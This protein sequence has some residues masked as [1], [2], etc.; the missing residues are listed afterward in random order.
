MP[1]TQNLETVK[2]GTTPEISFAAFDDLFK[3]APDVFS[4]IARAFIR[5]MKTTAEKLADLKG[6]LPTFGLKIAVLFHRF[7]TEKRKEPEWVGKDPNDYVRITL[8]LEK[9]D[10]VPPQAYANA[11]LYLGTVKP[12]K[13]KPVWTEADY[14]A[15]TQRALALLARITTHKKV[16][17]DGGQW[18]DHP[19]VT[20]A[21]KVASFRSKT[22]ERELAEIATEL[23]GDKPVEV[24]AE[25]LAR[26][27]NGLVAFL[28]ESAP[29]G[30]D[31]AELAASLVEA[32]EAW[33]AKVESEDE[34]AGDQANVDA[35]QAEAEPVQLPDFA[36][37]VGEIAPGVKPKLA[38]LIARGIE[39][40]HGALGTLP[41]SMDEL[42]SF[43]KAT[44]VAVAA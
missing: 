12:D 5:T 18:Q 4:K 2:P 16:K 38:K 34:E 25:N 14:L 29:K 28:K 26:V 40:F 3:S 30:E 36:G 10:R 24:T 23:D 39:Q 22:Y 13:R 37:H 19:V 27:V 20:K 6:E 41:V 42:D 17:D 33:N 32:A 11:R 15:C 1:N 43:M 44:K 31:F 7:C 9:A 8:G 35:E 21:L